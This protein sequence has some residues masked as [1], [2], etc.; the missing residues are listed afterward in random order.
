M[1]HTSK[2]RRRLHRVGA[3]LL[4]AL[5][6]FVAVRLLGTATAALEP[7]LRRVLRTVIV[8]DRSALGL[9]WL[10]SYALANGSVVA[11][12]SLSLFD[13]GVID[14]AVLFSMLVGSRL[15]GSGVV[16]LIGV[17]DYITAE[18]ESLRDAIRLGL[19]TFLLAHSVF[20][21]A[22]L[23]GLPLVPVV[24]V[25][26]IEVLTAVAIPTPIEI[27]ALTDAIVAGLGPGGAFVLALTLLF[28]CLQA[29]DRLL[30]RVDQERLRQ[31]YI[32]LVASRWV[33][34]AVGGLVTMV[35]TSVAFSLGVIV[36]LYNRGHI[37]REEVIPFALGANVGTFGDTLLVAL[38]LNTPVSVTIVVFLAVIATAVAVLA[39]GAGRWYVGTIERIQRRVLDHRYGFWGFLLALVIIP[40]GLLL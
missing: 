16:V 37:K 14:A 15:G 35:A 4:I 28:G 21:P 11:A 34:F 19:L 12:V 17:F 20:W 24:Q 33:A 27:T 6:F 13:S 29:F 25:T 22:M 9:S 38:T 5:V 39:L 3:G 30:E 1:A 2:R 36:P 31:R 7:V 10:A 23:I 8:A 32:T 18:T 40:V 26:P